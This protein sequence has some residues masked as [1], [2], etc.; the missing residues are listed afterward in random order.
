MNDTE[1]ALCALVARLLGLP[2][3]GPEDDFFALGGHSLTAARLVARIRDELGGA[4]TLRTVFE[5]PTVAGLATRLHDAPDPLAPLV[6]LREGDPTLFCVHPLGGLSWPYTR[7]GRPGAFGLH[8]LQADGLDGTGRL[9]GS[10]AEMAARYVERIRTVQPDGPYRLVGWSFGGHVAQEMAVQLK[11]SGA[12]VVLLAL[13]DCY[14]RDPAAAPSSEAE[15]LDGVRV[16]GELADPRT[17]RAAKAVFVNNDAI[18]ARHVPRV[19]AG[20][21]VFCRATRLADGETPR[22]PELW[23]P[24]VTGHIDVHPVD[25]THDGLLDEQ[26][27]TEIGGLLARLTERTNP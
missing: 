10:I 7:L 16:P 22:S 6:K 18:A 19:Y 27:A 14:P 5:S 3:I 9:P 4:L 26:A 21:V 25:A 8:G 23:R 2:E 11:E 20:D 13:L 17:L 1:R 24:H 15:L 12:E